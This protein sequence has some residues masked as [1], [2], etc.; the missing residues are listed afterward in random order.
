MR[1]RR[2]DQSS[3]RVRRTGKDELLTLVKLMKWLLN[4]ASVRGSRPFDG[5]AGSECPAEFAPD[6]RANRRPCKP[7]RPSISR[8]IAQSESRYSVK[9]ML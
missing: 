3:R 7:R 4:G 9:A 5:A 1:P 2:D 6:Y 8:A